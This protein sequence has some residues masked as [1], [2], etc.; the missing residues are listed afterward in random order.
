MCLDEPS[1]N[2]ASGPLFLLDGEQLVAD[3][4]VGLVPGDAL[5]LAALELHR[6][7]EAVRVVH[8]A[9]L[10]D[11]RALGAV[12]AEVERRIEHRLLADPHAVLHHRVDR[13][14]DRAVRADRALD[15]DLAAR[16]LVRG[17]RLAD[18]VERQL[19]RRRAGAERHARALEKGAPVHGLRQN[20]VQTR[21]RGAPAARR[22]P[23][24]FSSAAWRA[25]SNLVVR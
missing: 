3:L 11:R 18:H 12:R 25:S 16:G 23:V 5:P 19:R 7:L 13:A 4:L 24:L 6:R 1:T 2:S 21:A 20:A 10:A 17:L 15:L 9:V 22:S 8:H 14:T